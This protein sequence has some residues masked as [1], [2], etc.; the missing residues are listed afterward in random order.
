MTNLETKQTPLTMTLEEIGDA[1]SELA[2]RADAAPLY[3]AERA[4]LLD[5]IGRL[6]TSQGYKAV[7]Q[8]WHDPASRSTAS[9]RRAVTR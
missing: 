5:E 7:G 2:A 6:W 4:D 9:C 8:G 1:C 3:S